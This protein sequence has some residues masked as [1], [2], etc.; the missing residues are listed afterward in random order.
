[1]ASILGDA[2]HDLRVAAVMRTV[3]ARAVSEEALRAATH[4]E[5]DP[6]PAMLED[7]ARWLEVRD[8]LARANLTPIEILRIG[9]RAATG[10]YGGRA[11]GVELLAE[12][13]RIPEGAA[14]AR[15]LC[16]EVMGNGI[17]PPDA[18]QG[19]LCA[20]LARLA[21]E[22]NLQPALLTG[23]DLSLATIPMA[24]TVLSALPLEQREAVVLERIGG[25][26]DS[27][28]GARIVE[29]ILALQDLAPTPAVLAAR[30]RALAVVEAEDGREAL[31][32]RCRATIAPPP[33]IKLPTPS[34]REALAYWL[35]R[36]AAERQAARL[37]QIAAERWSTH[38]LPV[39]APELASLA[40]WAAAS[41]TRRLAVAEEVTRA[42]QQREPEQ[43]WHLVDLRR[44]GGPPIAVL[45]RG[46]ERFSLVPGGLVDVG[47]SE[48]EL[49]LLRARA[50]QQKGADNHHQQYESLFAQID[51]LRPVT[52]VRVDALLAAQ[53][54]GVV[55]AP[56]EATLAL[57]AGA[58]RVPS[59]AEWEHLARGARTG[60]L[61]YRGD[62]VPDTSEWY[63]GTGRL[64]IAG[65]NVFG[66]W[67]FGYEPELCAD[68]Y[69][70]SHDGLAA[71]G[72]PRR[73]E[74]PR[75]VRGGAAQVFPWQSCGE[76]QLL[77]SAMRGSEA[78][79]Q[80]HIALRMVLGV[81]RHTQG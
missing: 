42:A 59:E 30:A 27:Y 29:D 20:A 46:K 37:G 39:A 17:A 35:D 49:A 8:E 56:H 51:R 72:A 11:P 9:L 4:I 76:W 75:V 66:L 77:L 32:E 70:P 1:M 74:G 54:P 44:F 53:E 3:Q 48:R 41:D 71:D 12:M 60:E 23:V 14:A 81:G 78:A 28:R 55:H 52:R 6:S 43:G 67:G 19:C 64:G 5:S 45:A 18:L 50:E 65:A 62:E 10:A 13:F 26:P 79:W 25:E 2:T 16:A 24:R 58:L 21:A 47:V 80:F 38:N 34:A 73:G 69:A 36:R 61:T 31:E 15:A 68:L 33:P 57:E 22:G 63:F 7:T 40:A